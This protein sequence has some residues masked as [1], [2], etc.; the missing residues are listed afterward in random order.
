MSEL[1]N[2]LVIE[3]SY[4]DFLMVERQLKQNGMSGCC[5]R[6]D[7]LAELKEAI[8]AEKWDL[9][10]SDYNM[11]ELDFLE[12]QQLLRT[13]LPHVPVIMVTDNVDEEK[14]AEFLKH[15][16]W[17]FVLKEDLARLG[18]A[19]ERSLSDVAVRLRRNDADENLQQSEFM[20]RSLFDNMLNGFAYC[21]MIYDGETGPDFV[22][23]TVNDAFGKLT[24]LRNVIGKRVTEVIPGIKESDPELFTRYCRVAL[25]GMPERF[26]I[27]VDAMKIWFWISVYCPA[28]DHFIAIFDVIT[29][30]KLIENALAESEAKTRSILDNISI[31]VA[32][33]SPR[34]EIMELNHRMREWFPDIDPAGRSTCYRVFNDPPRSEECVHCPTKKTLRDGL[35]HEATTQTPQPGGARNYRVVSSPIFNAS[36]EVTAAI[37][38]VEDITEKLALESRCRQA[39][40]MEAVGQLAG[41]V[42]HDFNNILSAIFGYAQL[43]L[44]TLAENDTVKEYVEEIMKASERAAVLTKSLLTFSRKQVVDLA[45]I[46]LS[47]VVKNFEIFLHRLI[48]EDIELKVTCHENP[49]AVMADRGQIEQVIM[50]LVANGRDAMPNGGKLTIETLSMTMDQGLVAAQGYGA[51]GEYAV[52]S[53]TDSGSG[54]DKETQS[55]IFEPFYTTK[56]QGRGTGL[57]LSMAYGIIKKHDGFLNVYSEPGTGTIFR[58]YLP[59]VANVSAAD[60]T[61]PAVPTVLRGGTETILV[62]EDDAALRKLAVNI[63]SH[64]GYRVIEAVD[65]QDAVDKFVAHQESIDL[66]FIDAI[67]PKQ[68]GKEASNQMKLVRPDIKTIFVSGYA[69]D[70]FAGDIPFDRK[71]IFIHKPYSPNDLLTRTRELLDKK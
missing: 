18:P 50:N 17:D 11:P 16:V 33:I 25:T 7:S 67:M 3:D 13:G 54:M 37:E 20:Y 47:E 8:T 63:L 36:G 44:R 39:Q 19:I 34:M 10:L 22:Y 64:F 70:I 23:L 5:C 31:G 60:N 71:T 51:A 45:V 26:E 66:V 69:R 21:R 41:G 62:C 35:V 15:G 32:L 48:R 14:A 1:L 46:D 56:E 52:I 30:R 68:N 4:A 59:L 29:E 6:V 24:G 12:S 58:I 55:H 27:Y 38:M 57:G 43:S 65:G 2:I 61:G 9:V 42:A 49:L 53:V 28:R 40:K